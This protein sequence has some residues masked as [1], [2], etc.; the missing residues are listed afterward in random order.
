MQAEHSTVGHRVRGECSG[1]NVNSTSFAAVII[2]LIVRFQFLTFFFF[3]DSIVFSSVNT[4]FFFFL[5][6]FRNCWK[7]VRH[8]NREKDP[9]WRQRP[10]W[11]VDWMSKRIS[12]THPERPGQ[13]RRPLNNLYRRES[14]NVNALDGKWTS[15]TLRCLLREISPKRSRTLRH[16]RM[17]KSRWIICLVTDISISMIR[18]ISIQRLISTL[19]LRQISSYELFDGNNKFLR[20]IFLSRNRMFFFFV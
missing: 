4:V 14:S 3:N 1:K 16:K 2:S 6:R 7:K 8:R 18:L 5:I 19:I 10:S 9:F 20:K 17:H 15:Q 13:N 12:S 11:Q